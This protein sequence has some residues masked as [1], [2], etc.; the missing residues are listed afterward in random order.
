MR[1]HTVILRKDCKSTHDL[2]LDLLRIDIYHPGSKLD[3]NC[4]VVHWLKA[5]VS[6]LK[7]KA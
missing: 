6:K 1:K 2:Q 5:L 7:E 3:T 4:K